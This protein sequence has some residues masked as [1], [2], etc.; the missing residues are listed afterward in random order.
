MSAAKGLLAVTT[1]AGSWIAPVTRA[2]WV[3]SGVDH[4]HV[5]YGRVEL[6]LVGVPRDVDPL[7]VDQPTTLGVSPFLRELIREY[8]SAPYEIGPM[9][10]RLLAVLLDQLSATPRLDGALPM[11]TSSLLGAVAAAFRVDPADRRTLRQIGHEVGASER[12]LS[13]MFRGEVGMTF[14]QW[15]TRLRL[16]HALTLLANDIPVTAV[17]HRCGW[18]SAGAFISAFRHEYGYTP[19]R[20]SS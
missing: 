6:H 9:R 14:P 1:P 15:R 10:G 19:G 2:I 18:A 8:V 5:A 20:R 17:A 3:P 4:E 13:R 11:P 12:T 7:G 16:H